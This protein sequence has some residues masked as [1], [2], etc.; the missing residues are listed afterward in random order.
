MI[1]AVTITTW[2]RGVK[3]ACEFWGLNGLRHAMVSLARGG[4][5]RVQGVDLPQNTKREKGNE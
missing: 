1:S 4:E 5:G 3:P 2:R